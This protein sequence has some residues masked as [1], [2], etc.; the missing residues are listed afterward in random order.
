MA[1]YDIVQINDRIDFFPSGISDYATN[2]GLTITQDE[3]SKTVTLTAASTTESTTS[4]VVLVKTFA[5]PIPAEHFCFIM[6]EFEHP[7][8]NVTGIPICWLGLTSDGTT[9]DS[10]HEPIP[11]STLSY[12]KDTMQGLC[13][14]KG[15][16]KQILQVGIGLKGATQGDY[17]KIKRVAIIDETEIFGAD[18]ERG[19]MWCLE[20][21]TFNTTLKSF[22]FANGCLEKGDTIDCP[23]S[24]AAQSTRL[25]T[26]NYKLE[27]WGAQGGSYSTYLGGLGGYATGVLHL[28]EL[29]TL[30]LY[31]GGQ[32]ATVS[33][34]RTSV[35]GGFNGG[36]NGY[37]R[38]YSSTYTY[39]QGGGGA[40][41]IRIEQDSLYARVLVAGGGG[42]S[43]SLNDW[44]AKCRRTE[45]EED[46]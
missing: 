41:D 19:T 12:D 22:S 40:S 15:Y 18:N 36:G 27:C 31:A 25:P 21:F 24:G 42:G 3:D 2:A 14:I 10:W 34:N 16:T 5:N 35:A 6:F 37:N 9:V 7:S 1:K 26:G 11:T 33:T 38:Y 8:T 45:S 23:Y 30:Y 32:P 46:V 13:I 20:H 17:V 44:I 43:A 39:G 28:Q 4:G 29:T